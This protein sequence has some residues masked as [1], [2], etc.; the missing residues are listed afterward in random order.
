MKLATDRHRSR[1]GPPGCRR[2]AFWA[3]ALLCLLGQPLQVSAPFAAS[4]GQQPTFRSAI[5]LVE[6]AVIVRDRAGRFVG[7][8]APADFEVREAG[9]TQRVTAFDHVSIPLTRAVLAPGAA[10]LAIEGE[11]SEQTDESRIFVLVLDGLHV[12]PPRTLAVRAGARRFIEEHVPAGDLVAVVA[13]GAVEEATQDF[14]TDKAR[15]LAAVNRF[16][17]S[18]LRSATVEID[19]EQRHALA[20]G[21]AAHAGRDPSDAERADAHIR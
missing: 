8:L 4:Q 17:G 3:P 6:V 20:G 16:T 5:D 14:T 21:I 2:A 11:R 9:K 13:P 7:G 19:E 1:T 15:L 18:K 10:E 12:A